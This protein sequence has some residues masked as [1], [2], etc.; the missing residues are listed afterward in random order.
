MLNYN[1]NNI[2]SSLINS[3]LFDL[4]LSFYD[5]IKPPYENK[6]SLN[7]LIDE[8]HMRGLLKSH[9]SPFLIFKENYTPFSYIYYITIIYLDK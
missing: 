9:R 7:V 4:T 8:L 1:R 5:D 3:S 2:L 6:M